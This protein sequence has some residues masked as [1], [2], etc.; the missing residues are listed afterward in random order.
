MRLCLASCFSCLLS[1]TPMLQVCKVQ[2]ISMFSLHIT[3]CRSIIFNE[4]WS[5]TQSTVF[6]KTSLN[7]R[8]ATQHISC[9]ENN[10]ACNCH[11]IQHFKSVARFYDLTVLMMCYAISPAEMSEFWSKG[12]A[13]KC[14]LFIETGVSALLQP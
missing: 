2:Y 7:Q 13:E 11:S 10:I 4:I 12:D 3:T 5:S 1:H 14:L 9:R 6:L 8:F